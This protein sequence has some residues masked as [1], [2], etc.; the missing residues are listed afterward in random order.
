MEDLVYDFQQ[1]L[2][3]ELDRGPQEGMNMTCIDLLDK[4]LRS[5]Q[6]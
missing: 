6:V 1:G 3:M 2:D 5:N 4:K